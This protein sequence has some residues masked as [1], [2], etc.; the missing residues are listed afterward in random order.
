MCSVLT[1]SSQT[2]TNPQVIYNIKGA[3]SMR[4]SPF[5]F[6][7]C[8]IWQCN[9]LTNRISYICRGIWHT[10]KIAPI[11]NVVAEACDAV[12]A[13]VYRAYAIRPYKWRKTNTPKITFDVGKTMSDVEKIMSDIIQTTSDLFS[14]LANI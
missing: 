9:L 14:P 4:R 6:C 13:V 5:C 11:C 7:R 12:W 2:A 10:P 1:T 3:S 8:R